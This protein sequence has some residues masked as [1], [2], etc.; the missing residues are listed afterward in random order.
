M[1]VV[2]WLTIECKPFQPVAWYIYTALEPRSKYEQRSGISCRVSINSL[3]LVLINDHADMNFHSTYYPWS[4]TPIWHPHPTPRKIE[5]FS[6]A[7][8]DFM[9]LRPNIHQNLW[10][11][12]ML[13]S[14]IQGLN[15]L[16]TALA[17]LM[18]DHER[19][20]TAKLVTHHPW[21]RQPKFLTC[22]II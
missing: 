21:S 2:S 17:E 13:Q 16:K 4:R 10:S 15:M 5:H 20:F 22:T 7:K 6:Q 18:H 9:K 11:S 14:L 12:N 19:D 3:C 8:Q 1:Y